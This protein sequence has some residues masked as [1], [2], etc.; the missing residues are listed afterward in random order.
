MKS[1]LIIDDNI[2]L[3][4]FLVA[5]LRK[6]QYRTHIAHSGIKGMQVMEHEKPDLI[7]CDFRLPDLNG[8]EILNYIHKENKKIPLVIITAY[9]DV[10][11]A[12][13]MIKTGAFDYVTKPFIHEELL[14]T[15]KKGLQSGMEKDRDSKRGNEKTVE[16]IVVGNNPKI[17]QLFRQIDLVAPTTMSVMITGE[18]GTGKE[19]IAK[20]I[21]KRSQRA[22]GPFVAVDCG[23]IPKELASSELFGHEKGAF[24]SAINSKTGHFEFANG[25]TLFLDEIGNLPA[26]VQMTLLRAIEDKKI[27]KLGNNNLINL[28]IRLITATNEVLENSVREGKFREDLYYRINEFSLHIPPLRERTED[29][30]MLAFHFLKKSSLELKKNIEGFEPEVLKLF[31]TSQ[32]RGNLRELQNV[33]KRAV[34]LCNSTKINVQCLPYDFAITQSSP[35]SNDHALRETYLLKNTARVAENQTIIDVLRKTKF[36]H[37]EAAKILNINRKTLYNKLKAFEKNEN[38]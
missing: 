1:I 32:W 2:E 35:S 4:E 21:H 36:N 38:K 31:I 10:K 29:I 15:I 25:G 24:T 12:V 33:V 20:A 26:E 5:F 27:R 18:S 23:A 14:Y 3:C 9:P 16:E 37:T 17:K 22:T 34:L 19:V 13:N 28:D 6:H 30:E 8:E 7:L 11:M